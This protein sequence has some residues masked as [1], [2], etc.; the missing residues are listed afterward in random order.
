[1]EQ[2]KIMFTTEEGEQ[3]PFYIIEQTTIA[4]RNYLLVTDSGEDA[5]EADAYILKEVKD[6][7]GQLVCELVE[8]EQEMSAISKVFEELLE[9]VDL[10]M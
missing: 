9:D 5:E 8:E 6:E 1:M 7:N 2:D 4:G 10:T 3:I